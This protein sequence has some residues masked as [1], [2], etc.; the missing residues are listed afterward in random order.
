MAA[1]DGAGR[2]RRRRADTS[3]LQDAQQEQL[4]SRDA[5]AAAGLEA[6]GS[7]TNRPDVLTA[8]QAAAGTD[9]AAQASSPPTKRFRGRPPGAAAAKAKANRDDAAAPSTADAAPADPPEPTAAAKQK[10]ARNVSKKASSKSSSS[11]N[12]LSRAKEQQLW[13]QGYQAVA[14]VDEAGRGPLAGPVVAAA[15]VLPPG[16]E[17]ELLNDSKQMS[18]AD[19][20]AVFEQLTTHPEVSYAV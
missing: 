11:N 9:A 20:E 8:V 17:F 19:R 10:A 16:L 15:A 12:G 1:A 4:Q 5:G 6:L 13:S 3:K 14:G 18:E 7:I 2:R